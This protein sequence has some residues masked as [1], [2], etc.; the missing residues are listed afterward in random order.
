MS[1]EA[2][3]DSTCLIGLERI[4]QLDL[5]PKLFTHVYAP[6]VV[7]AE[8][9][10]SVEWLIVREVSNDSLLRALSTQL[11]AGESAVIALATEI[12]NAVAILDDKKA[13]RVAREMGL[14]MMG[15]VGLLVKAKREG[16]FS[17]LTPLLQD[18]D[19]VGF[20][21]SA[22]LHREALRLAG[23]EGS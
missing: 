2:A 21:L 15:T 10:H 6:S 7:L 19:R 12:Q 17:Q 8:L 11:G 22:E 9:G 20:R 16:V 5:L 18:L 13:R 4:Q 1:L 3:V 14:R 23:E